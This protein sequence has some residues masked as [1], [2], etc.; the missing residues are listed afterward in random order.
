MN[1]FVWFSYSKKE[2]MLRDSIR[3]FAINSDIPMRIVLAFDNIHGEVPSDETKTLFTE[4]RNKLN[5]ECSII[6]TKF[7][8]VFNLN[9]RI[10]I[11]NM[12]DIF[13]DLSKDMNENEA[14]FK[15]D[16]DMILFK[17]NYIKSFLSSDSLV[18]GLYRDPII[19][20]DID[21]EPNIWGSFYGL[22][23]GFIKALEKNISSF[24]STVA[25]LNNIDKSYKNILTSLLFPEDIALSYVVKSIIPKEKR[26]I[27]PLSM[28]GG[29]MAGWQYRKD[30]YSFYYDMYELVN[31][32]N[33]ALVKSQDPLRFITKTMREALDDFLIKNKRT[34]Y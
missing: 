22:K 27:L 6:L 21:K 15:V 10:C 7:D 5:I 30:P 34:R 13:S 29:F 32:G 8:R 24:G 31:F 9:G 33:V 2:E 4:I 18:L 28:K 26:M 11:S 20:I 17:D 14:V 1:T 12:Y 25:F 23:K 16:D 3:S 19:D